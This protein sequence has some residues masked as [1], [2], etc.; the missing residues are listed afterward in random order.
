[1]DENPHRARSH[2]GDGASPRHAMRTTIRQYATGIC[3]FNTCVSSLA[4]LALLL[5]PSRPYTPTK[6]IVMGTLLWWN[7]LGHPALVFVV[8]WSLIGRD[9]PFCKYLPL[10]IWCAALFTQWIGLVLFVVL[11]AISEVGLFS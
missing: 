4:V 5:V 10:K 2:L 1:M 6:D 3:M 7:L 8:I 9:V 11:V